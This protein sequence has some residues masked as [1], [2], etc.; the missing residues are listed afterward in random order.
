MNLINH[1]WDGI[2]SNIWS[3]NVDDWSIATLP[4]SPSHP[5]SSPSKISPLLI[6]TIRKKKSPSQNSQLKKSRGREEWSSMALASPFISMSA[7]SLVFSRERKKK[8][9]YSIDWLYFLSIYTKNLCSK[10]LASVLQLLSCLEMKAKS[11]ML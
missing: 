5:I 10:Q 6:F 7:N 1:Y 11:I 8:S 2:L 4:P 3:H 9:C